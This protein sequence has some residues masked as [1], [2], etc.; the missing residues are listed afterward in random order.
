[1]SDP[2]AQAAAQIA[3]DAAPSSTKPPLLTEIIEEFKHLG[4]KVEHLIHPEYSAEVAQPG[5]S[6]A[7]VT[8]SNTPQTENAADTSAT[9]TIPAI[10]DASDSSSTA[11]ESN[12]GID[13]NV[14]AQSAAEPSESDTSSSANPASPVAGTLAAIDSS[15]LSR[16]RLAI[17]RL[18][19]HFWTFEASA[20]Q[21][22][23]TELDFLEGLF[24]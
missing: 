22:M 7:T 17:D 19:A 8:D 16:A 11:S 21:K 13:P 2:V 20:V 12:G 10:A 24:K 1:M 23:H 18:R 4:E 14:A 9:D 3:A 15:V 5:E 6:S